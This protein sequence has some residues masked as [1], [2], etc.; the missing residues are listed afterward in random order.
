MNF[1]YTGYFKDITILFNSIFD[2]IVVLLF[3]MQCWIMPG[4]TP[5][6][7]KWHSY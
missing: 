1:L 2:A 7:S 4:Q 5:M 6:N 3:F